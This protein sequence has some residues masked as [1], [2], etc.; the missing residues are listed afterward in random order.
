MWHIACHVSKCEANAGRYNTSSHKNNAI[1]HS[2][3]PILPQFRLGGSLCQSYD[4]I[5]SVLFSQLFA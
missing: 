3:T 2:F 4:S 5:V 1:W